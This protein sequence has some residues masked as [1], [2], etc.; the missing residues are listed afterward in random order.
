MAHQQTVVV[1]EAKKFE[2]HIVIHTQ[3]W[4]GA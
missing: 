2:E 4:K 3:P 1:S